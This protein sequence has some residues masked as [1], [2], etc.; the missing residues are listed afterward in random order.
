MGSRIWSAMKSYAIFNLLI[1]SVGIMGFVSGVWVFRKFFLHKN[2]RFTLGMTQSLVALCSALAV[3]IVYD[4][5][6]IARNGWFY[7]FQSN[8]PN[9]IQGIGQVV[10]SLAVVEVSPSGLEATIFEL[11]TSA[12]NG[13]IALS[14]SLQ[15]TFGHVFNLD[16]IN[17]NTFYDHE[18]EYANR[19][20]TATLFCLAVNLTGALVFVWFLPKNPEQ[21]HEWS[22]KKSWHTNKAGIL[23]TL[24]F[25]G[26]FLY[27]NVS[28]MRMIIG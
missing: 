8:V 12:F 3:M 6:G 15:T 24:V 13:A 22:G 2:W 25:A 26:P 20:A 23:N 27:A 5:F 7:M 14:A 10:T 18:E 11:L 1:Q 16:E 21:C 19:L 28:V 4:T 17:A 9:F